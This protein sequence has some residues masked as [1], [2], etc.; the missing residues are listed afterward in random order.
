MLHLAAK[1]QFAALVRLHTAIRIRRAFNMLCN[2]KT[3]E[4]C[5][6]PRQNSVPLAYLNNMQ[7]GSTQND[8]KDVPDGV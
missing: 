8:A 3:M 2:C 7:L 6:L 5:S 1:H 4:P